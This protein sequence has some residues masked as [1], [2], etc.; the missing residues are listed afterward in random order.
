MDHVC[1]L[2]QHLWDKIGHIHIKPDGTPSLGEEDKTAGASNVRKRR[3]RPKD[4]RLHAL[5][6]SLSKYNMMYLHIIRLLSV[7]FTSYA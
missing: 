4:V 5:S 6:R 2:Q 1:E 3:K 7:V